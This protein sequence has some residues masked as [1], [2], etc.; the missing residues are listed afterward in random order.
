MRL[1]ISDVKDLNT[2]KLRHPDF[3]EH[4][5]KESTRLKVMMLI[6]GG[7]LDETGEGKM[8]DD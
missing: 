7:W 8:T 3:N 1:C 4:I 5:F 2:E 6:K